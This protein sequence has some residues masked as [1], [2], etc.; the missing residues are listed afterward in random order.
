MFTIL[1]YLSILWMD[2]MAIEEVLKC[3]NKRSEIINIV[4]KRKLEYLGHIMRNQN[5]YGLLLLILQYKIQSKRR[6]GRRIIS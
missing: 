5:R 4:K 2:R 3:M 1:Q 6:P